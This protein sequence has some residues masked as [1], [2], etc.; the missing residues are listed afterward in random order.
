MQKLACRTARI[1]ECI[2]RILLRSILLE[3]RLVIFL[4]FCLNCGVF[5]VAGDCRQA[6][7]ALCVCWADGER[8]GPSEAA[9]HCDEHSF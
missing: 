6:G 7:R 9:R 5:K 1:S 4:V 3:S 8:V 2:G